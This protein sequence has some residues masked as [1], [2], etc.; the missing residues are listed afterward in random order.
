MLKYSETS[1]DLQYEFGDTG[2]GDE[3]HFN[4]A[5]TKNFHGDLTSE[6]AREAIQNSIDAHK[7]PLSEKPVIIDFKLTNLPATQLPNSHQLQEIFKACLEYHPDEL[8]GLIDYE[9]EKFYSEAVNKLENNIKISVL[10]ISDTNTTGMSPK[11]AYS[12]LRAIGLSAGKESAAGG[13]HGLG[14]GAYFSASGFRTV[15]TTSKYLDDSYIFQGKLRIVSHKDEREVIKQGNGSFG[16]LG[17]N[18]VTDRRLIPERFSRTEQGTSFFIIDYKDS[19]NFNEKIIKSVLENYWYAVLT[20]KLVVRITAGEKTEEINYQNISTLMTLTYDIGD[21]QPNPRPFFEAVTDTS[22]HTVFEKNSD[23]LGNI[24]LFF[25]EGKGYPSKISYIRNIGMTVNIRGGYNFSK[26]YVAVFICDNEKGGS[27]LRSMENQTHNEWKYENAKGRVHEEVAKRADRE[28]RDFIHDIFNKLL[29]EMES[30][31]LPMPGLEKYFPLKGDESIG[32]QVNAGSGDHTGDV[33]ERENFSEIGVT[34][35]IDILH[36]ELSKS[37]PVVTSVNRNGQYGVEVDRIPKGVRNVKKGN[38]SGVE[39]STGSEEIKVPL[40]V[41]CRR[42]YAQNTVD[43]DMVHVLIFEGTDNRK[44][45]IR[46]F[47]G[48]DLGYDP[49]NIIKATDIRNIAYETRENLV[50]NFKLD[51]SGL[52]RL[53]VQFEDNQKYSIKV[54]CYEN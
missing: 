37:I 14:K 7:M 35:H 45:G 41:K 51:E 25:L 17:Q 47:A 50:R 44:F 24:K 28:I 32:E 21:P 6:L 39:D 20:K 26:S 42:S 27:I 16:L 13:S 31:S 48:T 4:D 3:S 38:K 8:K 52:S 46:I 5:V 23:L 19:T 22:L 1:S 34:T 49:L 12:F 40:E 30:E 33:T 10:E 11:D 53:F 43:G 36:S 15:F 2:G 18:P 29:K 54:E 9:K